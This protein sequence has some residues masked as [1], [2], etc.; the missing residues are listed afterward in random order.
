MIERHRLSSSSIDVHDHSQIHRGSSGEV[1]GDV[2]S[3]A[4]VFRVYREV[5]FAELGR[6]TELGP[7]HAILARPDA[8]VLSTTTPLLRQ[9]APSSIRRI[10]ETEGIASAVQVHGWR[11]EL[12]RLRYWRGD[13]YLGEV[14]QLAIPAMTLAYRL[15]LLTD[16]LAAAR[17]VEA[18]MRVVPLSDGGIQAEWTAANHHINHLEVAMRPERL[19]RY[20][21]LVTSETPDGQIASIVRE[22]PNATLIEVVGAFEEYLTRVDNS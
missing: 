7:E 21:L 12:E 13:P 9:M 2:Q 4:S 19:D 18:P 22:V 15:G 20:D 17:G 8:V 5:V 10:A 6:S 16:A 11:A 14:E 1:T 3:K